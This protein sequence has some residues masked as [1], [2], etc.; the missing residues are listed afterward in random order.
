MNFDRTLHGVQNSV[1]AHDSSQFETNRLCI[2]VV[3]SLLQ[4]CPRTSRRHADAAERTIAVEVA[5]DAMGTVDGDYRAGGV[6][7]I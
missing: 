6:S 3:F 1:Q 4:R 2:V 5:V 7:R